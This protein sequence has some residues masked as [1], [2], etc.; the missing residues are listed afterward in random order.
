[1]PDLSAVPTLEGLSG[2]VSITVT[3]AKIDNF[4]YGSLRYANLAARGWSAYAT[5]DFQA[6]H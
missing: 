4:D 6:H 3:R 5:D 1:L 2:P